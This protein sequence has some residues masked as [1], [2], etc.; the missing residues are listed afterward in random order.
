MLQKMFLKTN[1][2]LF[3]ASTMNRNKELSV[4]VVWHPSILKSLFDF[5]ASATTAE[6]ID[7]G[8]GKETPQESREIQL[9]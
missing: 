9:S 7:G 3:S 6:R 5:M 2:S 8:D 1:D 4:Q